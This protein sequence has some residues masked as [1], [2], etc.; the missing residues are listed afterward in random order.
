M[1]T[2]GG[3]LAQR[4]RALLAPTLPRPCGR[5]G[6]LVLAWQAWDVGHIV[7]VSAHPELMTDPRNWR[8]EHSRCN[9]S[10]GAAMGNRK[11]KRPESW[12]A[13]GW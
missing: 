4:A 8:V 10:A 13:P 11:R 6:Q 3:S 7:D 5:C 12:T 9:R 1:T 2:W